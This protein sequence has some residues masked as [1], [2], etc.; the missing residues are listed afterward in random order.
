MVSAMVTE[1]ILH[2]LLETDGG[3]AKEFRFLLIYG[4]AT[5]D[6]AMTGREC[7][8]AAVVVL[9]MG[10]EPGHDPG[11]VREALRQHL[12]DGMLLNDHLKPEKA[13]KMSASLVC[14]CFTGPGII[15]SLLTGCDGFSVEI[16]E[17]GGHSR[18]LRF[19]AGPASAIIDIRD[20]IRRGATVVIENKP[21]ARRRKD[22]PDPSLEP[23]PRPRPERFQSALATLETRFGKSFFVPVRTCLEDGAMYVYKSNQL[24]EGSERD[25]DDSL[26]A[27]AHFDRLR[28]PHP[29]VYIETRDWVEVWTAETARKVD[30][31]IGI[32]A[33]EE[34]DGVIHFCGMCEDERLNREMSPVF[35]T[36]DMDTM[37]TGARYFGYVLPPVP[38]THHFNEGNTRVLTR[39]A[40]D[41]LLELLFLLN[42]QGVE[43]TRV[44]PTEM[45]VRATTVAE[46]RRQRHQ[47]QRKARPY[48]VIRVPLYREDEVEIG[49]GMTASGGTRWVRPHLR[50]AHVWGRYTRPEEEQRLIEATLVNAKH[51]K[52]GE[53]IARPVHVVKI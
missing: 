8:D 16:T 30:I 45:T 17:Q 43:A 18:N 44:D 7:F 52:D 50:S 46:R 15:Q 2:A 14:Y 49:N 37:K 3:F 35:G 47:R 33:W 4:T 27:L 28:L 10:Q 12:I 39:A 22:Q 20:K 29:F 26:S 51:L 9:R 48:N 34:G 25:I 11:K 32:A 41:H 53:E 24:A 19:I 6:F 38:K 40:G 36:V 42:T 21:G 5:L 31:R 13:S 1:D 23:P